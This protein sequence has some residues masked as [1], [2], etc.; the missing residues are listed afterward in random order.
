VNARALADADASPPIRALR[1]A[2]LG[3]RL[4]AT[5]TADLIALEDGWLV[6]LYR[7]DV[8]FEAI[9]AQHRIDA[10]VAA[11][12]LPLPRVQAELVHVFDKDRY[13]IVYERID[14]V[15]MATQMKRHPLQLFRHAD[16]LA[17]LHADIHAQRGAAELPSLK[18]RL[19]AKLAAD[20]PLA[21]SRR[22]H[23]QGMLDGLPDGDALCHG[24]FHWENVIVGAS[25]PVA[26]DWSDASRGDPLCDVARSWVLC[27]FNDQCGRWT[28]RQVCRLFCRI[29][30][31]DYL[32]RSGRDGRHVA[33][34]QLVNAAARMQEAITP[35][36]KTMLL[37]HLNTRLASVPT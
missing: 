32:R 11:T 7:G 34:W 1:S 17:R 27:G 3:E 26:I 5:R 14:G 30:V 21:A 24:D 37:D 22:R 31:R 16:A 4:F 20:S 6:K 15:S 8:A 10:L 36:E 9:A 25:Q 12:G 23:L 33:A 35:L 2:Q 19:A 29:Y 28:V 13:G 18:Q